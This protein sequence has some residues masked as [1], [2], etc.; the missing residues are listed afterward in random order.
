MRFIVALLCA[1][2]LWQGQPVYAVDKAPGQAAPLIPAAWL[3][4]KVSVAEAEAEHPGQ[5]DERAKQHPELA[6]PFGA[7]N[8]KWE[9][10]KADMQ[11]NDELWTFSSPPRTWEDLAGRAGIAL[12]RDGQVI[13]VIVTM[14]N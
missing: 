9:A 10:L 2:L 6:R 3:I 12:V 5:R 11:P 1:M 7:L 8:V 14:L 4:K 13:E